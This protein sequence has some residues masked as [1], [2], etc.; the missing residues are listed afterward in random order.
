MNRRDLVQ[1]MVFGGTVL[2]FVPSVLK[3]CAKGPITNPDGSVPGTTI[4]VDLS[5]ADNVPLNTTGGSKLVQSILVI[6]TG[7]G[8]IALSSVCTHQGCTVAYDPAATNIKCPCHG[9]VYST[10][11]SVIT[12]PAP[13]ALQSYPVSKVGNILTI[14]L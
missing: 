14:T 6:N 4:N 12:G 3:S 8:F 10:T 7:S 2:L 13:N 11:G 5:L 9:S 1:K